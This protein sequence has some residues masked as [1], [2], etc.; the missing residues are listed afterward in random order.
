MQRIEESNNNARDRGKI[1]YN[2]SIPK[3]YILH[4]IESDQC[5]S[6]GRDTAV[7]MSGDVDA[8]NGCL[9]GEVLHSL[10]DGV[11]K[12]KQAGSSWL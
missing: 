3:Q 2:F 1:M 9:C 11:L 10:S 12:C 5:S 4:L 6:S 8:L 7:E